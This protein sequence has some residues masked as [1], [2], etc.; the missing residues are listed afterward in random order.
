[1]SL[2][3]PVENTMQKRLLATL[4]MGALLGASAAHAALVQSGTS[5]YT[6][7]RNCTTTGTTACDGLSS[8]VIGSIGGNPGDSSASASQ[9]SASYGSASG[10]VALSGTAG[11]PIFSGDAIS[12][13]NTRVST[14]EAALQR[15]TYTGAAAT[16]R[17]F[18]GSL[19]YTQTVPAANA[20]FP[21]IANSGVHVNMQV[22]TLGGDYL[23]VGTT[24]AHNFN[25]LSGGFMAAAGYVELG[26]DTFAD[27]GTHAGGTGALGIT[28]TLN[29]GDSVWIWAYLQTP[30]AN[31]AVVSAYSLATGWDNSNDLT[32]A[33][34]VPEP[35]TWAL[36]GLCLAGLGWAR[37]RQACAP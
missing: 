9:S 25:A 35:G 3:Q 37:R 29:P 33:N 31:G 24:S 21:G 34:S 11:A 8:V 20:A 18:G 6:T 26:N 28:V 4:A 17:T 19:S 12:L 32:P 15:Y 5:V 30:A 14:N 1:M 36:A 16:T 23:D 22:F 13:A 27:L 10:S 7:F 2:G